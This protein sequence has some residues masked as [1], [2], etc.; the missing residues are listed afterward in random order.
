V[1]SVKRDRHSLDIGLIEEHPLEAIGFLRQS[2]VVK[3]PDGAG[4]PLFP[5]WPRQTRWGLTTPPVGPTS[6]HVGMFPRHT[7]KQSRPTVTAALRLCPSIP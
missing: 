1:G 3:Y 6:E 7:G 5:G 2:P 4:D